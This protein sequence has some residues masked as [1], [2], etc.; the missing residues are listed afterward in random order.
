MFEI[1]KR[2]LCIQVAT[3]AASLEPVA[4]DTAGE[5]DT[6]QMDS[7]EFSKPHKK[8]KC[9]K[10]FIPSEFP[11]FKEQNLDLTIWN[12]ITIFLF[13]LFTMCNSSD[14]IFLW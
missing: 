1:R 13:W 12:D 3:V 10:S 5:V 9:R 8:Y 4:I 2:N 6:F 14:G 7:G 11:S